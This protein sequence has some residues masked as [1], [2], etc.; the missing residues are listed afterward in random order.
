MQAEALLERF[1]PAGEGA[2]TEIVATFGD[3]EGEY[4]AIRKACALMD[5]AHRATVIVRGAD[6]LEFLQRML[7]QDVSRKALPPYRAARSFWLNRKGRIDADLRLIELEDRCVIDVDAI[8][9]PGLVRTLGEF[10]FAEDVLFEGPGAAWRRIA[11]HGPQARGAA[12]GAFARSQGPGLEALEPGGACVGE[13]AGVEV[14]IDRQDSTGEVGLEVLAPS[15]GVGR[16]WDALLEAGGGDAVQPAGWHAYNIA[17]IEAGWALH[18]IDFGPESLAHETGVLHDRV[19]F[20]KGCYLG[21]EVVARMDALGHPKQTLA[22][23]LIDP[24]ASP[25]ENAARQPEAGG[26]VLAETGEDSVGAVTSSALSPALGDAPVCFAQVRFKHSA[27]GT[28]L[29]VSA[30]A[31]LVSATVREGLAFWRR[32]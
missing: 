6:R 4:A 29:R 15:D 31:G 26:A 20:K 9:A 17:R 16:V 13:I 22:A 1:G 27:P 28:R 12:A 23:L 32:A 10:V 5:M 19:S 7:T 8:T 14:V 18:L 2:G 24:G 25:E 21:Q 30:P 3:I 11:L